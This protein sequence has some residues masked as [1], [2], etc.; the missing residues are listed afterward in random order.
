MNTKIIIK[1]FIAAV[2][3]LPLAATAEQYS[4]QMRNYVISRDQDVK[5][6]CSN[7]D[8]LIFDS[9]AG[10][11]RSAKEFERIPLFEEIKLASSVSCRAKSVH[12]TAVFK[13]T[14]VAVCAKTQ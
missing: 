5:A 11:D 3:F 14:A 8:T 10:V 4:V 7:G 12:P 13:V 9:C 6:I 1:L 2:A